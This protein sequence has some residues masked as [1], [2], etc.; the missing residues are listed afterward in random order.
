[1]WALA[2]RL[3]DFPSRYLTAP[4]HSSGG[5]IFKYAR[6]A[7]RKLL[8]EFSRVRQGG[9][10]I[11]GEGNYD[12]SINLHIQRLLEA[13]APIAQRTAPLRGPR[14]AGPPTE[15]HCVSVLTFGGVHFV[16]S[17]DPLAG[18][19]FSCGTAL[20]VALIALSKEGSEPIP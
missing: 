19:A 15:G 4:L 18:A 20:L 8:N 16:S 11:F 3:L 9:R 6:T 2:R 17:D 7:R 1:V 12:L 13:A 10:R 14:P 5:T